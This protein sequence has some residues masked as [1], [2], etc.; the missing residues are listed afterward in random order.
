ML[1][2]NITNFFQGI[3]LGVAEIIPGVSG[4]TMALIMGIYDDFINLLYQGSELA[5][6][7]IQVLLGKKKSPELKNA[8]FLI[9]WRFGLTLLAGMLTAIAVLSSVIQELLVQVP[10]YVYAIL[11][12]LTVPAML[13]VYQHQTEKNWRNWGITGLTAAVVL[14]FLIWG[15]SLLGFSGQPGPIRL[16]IGGA[17]AVSTMIL[18]GVSGSFVLLLLGLYGYVVTSISDFVSLSAS[19]EQMINLVFLGIGVLIGFMT[20]VR[21]VKWA[22]KHA[23]NTLMAILLG[24]LISSWYVL[25]PVVQTTAV[26]EGEP[27]IEK[28]PTTTFLGTE[29]SLLAL[30]VIFSAV[31]TTAV[32]RWADRND[33]D[34]PKP[35]SSLDVG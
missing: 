22:F 1:L 9:K 35:D 32:H 25:W 33:S 28:V 4:S 34:S 16:L 19:P 18:P 31:A 30:L 11:L 3:I 21:V 10:E 27:V 5:K 14:S 13:I 6:T 7:I 23:A 8:F 20:S 17:M 29:L 15:E 12:G 2:K 24:L 26:I